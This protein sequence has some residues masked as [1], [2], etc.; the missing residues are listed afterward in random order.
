MKFWFQF[1]ASASSDATR[2]QRRR[3]LLLAV[4]GIAVLPLAW[5]GT[6]CGQDF[7]FHLQN[8]QE[9]VAHWQHGVI[10]PHWA[11]SANYLAGEPRFVFYPPLSWLV[12]G[13]LGAI[14]PWT[15][16]P[17]AFTLLALLGAGFGFRAMARE[18][19]PEDS[20]T[21]AACLYVVNPYMLF[22]AYERGAMA[23]LLAATWLPL[24]VLYGLRAKRSFLPLAV[25]VAAIWLTN[26]PAG[27]MGC[28]MLAVLVVVVAVQ[29]K[30]WRVVGRAAGGTALGLGLAGF[31]LIPALYEQRWV[32]IARAIGP[33]MRVEDSF[34]FG[35]AKL[36]GASA[37]ERFDIVYH[38]QVLRTVSWIVV[39]LI[40]GAVVAAW[41]ARRK[42]NAI[43]MPLVVV[44]AGVCILQLRWSDG[45]WWLAP[46]L[47]FLQFP[48]R[49]M[50]VLGLVF[51]ALAGLA[52]RG[53]A[54][55]RR[56]IA[57]RAAMMLLLAGGMA[58][59][60]S[61]L[62]WQPCDE[63]DN[64]QAQIATFHDRG[65][66]GTDEYTP[67]NADNSEIQQAL[68]QV[69]LLKTP[70]AEEASDSNNS[71]WT[72]D[73]TEEISAGVTVDRWNPE[74]K[75][76]TITSE[77]PGYAVLRLMDYPAW[78]VTR[79]NADVSERARRSD[80]LMA[81]P[82]EAGTNHIDVRWRITT[83]QWAGIGLSL[84]ALAITLAF[85]WKGRRRLDVGGFR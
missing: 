44:G 85:G 17:V 55:T 29:E 14:L 22:V 19:M 39:S 23:E 20:A 6:S 12:G 34:L 31:W 41:L 30:N 48:W 65:F 52:L 13:L 72:A 62:F 64:V 73:P 68:P 11:E 21:I 18:W 4:V 28:Y 58:V 76:I 43:W 7:D 53:E 67:Q 83:D 36:A 59:L 70:N 74:H 79:N 26:A 66:G 51:A 82:V 84:G 45:V 71:Q 80:G 5:R 57:V 81:I 10:Y 47:K 2:A 24:L 77:Q 27:V 56:A 69:R 42:R 46:E 54:A 9:V 3:S 33:L 60:S 63:E 40:V 35:Y 32:E 25:T 49:W 50:M 37:D 61:M 8:W 78:R 75:S 16:T 1:P 15:W 38:N